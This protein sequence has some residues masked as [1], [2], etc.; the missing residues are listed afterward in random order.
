MNLFVSSVVTPP[1]HLPI[2][3]DVE[4]ER[5]ALAVVDEVERSV[6]WRAIVEQTRRI[7]VDGPLRPLLQLEPVMAITSITR[8]T[9]TDDAEVIPAATYQVVTRDPR[10]TILTPAP[11]SAWPAPER[12]IGSFELLYQCGWSV[13]ATENKVPASVQLMIERAIEFR[14][15]PRGVSAIRASGVDIP[16][17]AAY[18]TDALPRGIASIGRTWAYRPGLFSAR[19]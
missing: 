8:W 6:L 7:V 3:V 18:E 4:Q 14:T 9:E 10:G 13:T 1:A 2:E 19:P 15:G 16:I 11:G 5:L 12:P 17:A